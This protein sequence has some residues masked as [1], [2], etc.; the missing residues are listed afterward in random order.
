MGNLVGMPV[1][2]VPTGFT[3]ISNLPPDGS[4]RRATITTGIY[5]PP[6]HDHVV[7]SMIRAL[8]TDFSIKKINQVILADE[9]F[10]LFSL[11]AGS[12]TGHGLPVS[13]RA[14]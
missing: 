7:R 3:Q 4:R 12:R 8:F 13:H 6:N 10:V 5:A 9:V 1:L 2:I 11:C 14:P